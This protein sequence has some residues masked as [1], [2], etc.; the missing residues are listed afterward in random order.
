MVSAQLKPAYSGVIYLLKQVGMDRHPLL[1]AEWK[2]S[3]RLKSLSTVQELE[4]ESIISS[5][6]SKKDVA[7][8][9]I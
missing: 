5:P 4:S 1:L 9:L 6:I 2:F 7:F 8:L 3:A